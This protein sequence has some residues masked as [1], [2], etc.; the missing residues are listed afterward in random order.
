MGS[1][2]FKLWANRKCGL[3]FAYPSSRASAFLSRF[4]TASSLPSADLTACKD[5]K[6]HF[7]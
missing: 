7:D 5:S 3:S 1:T 4:N 6:Q 2:A